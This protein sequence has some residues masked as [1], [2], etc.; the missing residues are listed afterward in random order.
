MNSNVFIT[1]LMTEKIY[2]FIDNE[3]DAMD[4]NRNMIRIC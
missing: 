4:S 1:S 3:Y 2:F